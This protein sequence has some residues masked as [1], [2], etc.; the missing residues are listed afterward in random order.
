LRVT[1]PKFLQCPPGD[2]LIATLYHVTNLVTT[3]N[4][5]WD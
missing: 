4:R 1:R 2:H 3:W 5:R